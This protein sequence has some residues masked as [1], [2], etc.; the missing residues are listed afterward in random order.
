MFNYQNQN[1]V[2]ILLPWLSLSY[3]VNFPFKGHILRYDTYILCLKKS[4]IDNF[5]E[6]NFN[7]EILSIQKQF[8]KVEISVNDNQNLPPQLNVACFSLGLFFF[9]FSF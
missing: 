3:F 9:L 7:N 4:L 8:M 2:N 5:G 6:I 1:W